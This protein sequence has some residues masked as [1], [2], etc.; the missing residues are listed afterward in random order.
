MGDRLNKSPYKKIATLLET[1]E[2]MLAVC[3]LKTVPSIQKALVGALFYDQDVY[4]YFYLAVTT[5]RVLVLPLTKT[6]NLLDLKKAF[7]LPYT[8][9]SSDERLIY[10]HPVDTPDP[11]KLEYWSGDSRTARL[12]KKDFEVILEKQKF[13]AG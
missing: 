5:S 6:L 7:T 8:G 9:V 13:I 3:Y 1:G 2:E 4:Q 11:I 12:K 10:L